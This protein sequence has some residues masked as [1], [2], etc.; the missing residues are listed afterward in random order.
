MDILE[1]VP[2]IFLRAI[3]VGVPLVSSDQEDLLEFLE[4]LAETCGQ[5]FRFDQGLLAAV[6][7]ADAL[8]SGGV[9]KSALALGLTDIQVRRETAGEVL[10]SAWR[11]R[12]GERDQATLQHHVLIAKL[13]ATYIIDPVIKQLNR[14]APLV[15][16]NATAEHYGLIEEQA[17]YQS[18][19]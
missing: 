7:L 14:N 9:D 3:F 18:S 15:M 4:A 2:R 19:N 12:Y 8:R 1:R 17:I 16:V 13:D 10:A 6:F 11:A 5:K